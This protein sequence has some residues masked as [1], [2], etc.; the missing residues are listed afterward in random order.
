M[1]LNMENYSQCQLQIKQQSIQI[2]KIELNKF[3]S[4]MQLFLRR[5]QTRQQLKG[6]TK[7]QLRDV[8]IDAFAAQQEVNKPFWK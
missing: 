7:E 5:Y 8:G 6:L 2:K 4:L 3:L 1:R